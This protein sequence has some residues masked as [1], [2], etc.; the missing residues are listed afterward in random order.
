M[1]DDD[2][3]TFELL[4]FVDWRVAISSAG[5]WAREDVATLNDVL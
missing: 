4:A 5:P 1:I 2:S 3:G